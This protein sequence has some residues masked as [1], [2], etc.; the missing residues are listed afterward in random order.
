MVSKEF[1]RQLEGYGLTTATILY[2]IPDHPQLLQTYIW[3]EYDLFPEFPVLHRFLDFW[4]HKLDGV[5][6]SVTVGH[7]RLIRPAELKTVGA[8]CRD[9]GLFLI[10]DGTIQLVQNGFYE[11]N[12][13]QLE[14]ELARIIEE[15]GA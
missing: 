4:A 14:D 12:E 7:A 1:M 2:R 8:F 13:E 11:E 15:R 10:S 9:H 6:H 5:L 3:Q